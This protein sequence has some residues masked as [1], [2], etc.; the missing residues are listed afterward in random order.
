MTDSFT[1]KMTDLPQGLTSDF[2]TSCRGFLLTCLCTYFHSYSP[3]LIFYQLMFVKYFAIITHPFLKFGILQATCVFS[4]L[5]HINVY[6]SMNAMRCVGFVV[7]ISK[8]VAENI[9]AIVFPTYGV[10]SKLNSSHLI[11]VYFSTIIIVTC[12]TKTCKCTHTQHIHTRFK[13]LSKPRFLVS[14][15]FV[16][17]VH[18][19]LLFCLCSF[20]IFHVIHLY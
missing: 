7:Q 19:V 20:Y 13:N 15:R 6:F 5:L 1:N 8:F 16:F 12:N 11:T 3:Y 18:L 17:V 14:D 9:V 4:H 10:K 2:L